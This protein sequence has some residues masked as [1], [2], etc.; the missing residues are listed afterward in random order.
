MEELDKMLHLHCLFLHFNDGTPVGFFK[1]TRG[2]RQR[3]PLSLYL[4]IL[5]MEALS[6]MMVR[7]VSNGY[8]EG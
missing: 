7:A 1:T 3:D 5:V 4:F 6:W 8:L 2:L